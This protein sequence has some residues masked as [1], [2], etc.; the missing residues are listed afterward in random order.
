MYSG[1]RIIKA[2][3]FVFISII[4]TSTIFATDYIQL[5][6]DKSFNASKSK[7]DPLR[8]EVLG[9]QWFLP[10]TLKK[11]N[12][13][14]ITHDV[15]GFQEKVPFF[16]YGHKSFQLVNEDIN[17]NS[18]AY[19]DLP[20]PT[21]NVSNIF[22]LLNAV[23]LLPDGYLTNYTDTV[24]RILLFYQNPESGETFV[25]TENGLPGISPS[26][27]ELELKGGDMVRNNWTGDSIFG[28]WESN[29]LASYVT[30]FWNQ[31][32]NRGTDSTGEPYQGNDVIDILHVSLPEELY[33]YEL[34][35]IGISP[36]YRFVLSNDFRIYSGLMLYGI[37]VGLPCIN[38]DSPEVTD[39]RFKFKNGDNGVFIH[40]L[41]GTSFSP[42]FEFD[43]DWKEQNSF[44]VELYSSDRLEWVTLDNSN[45]TVFEGL[46]YKFNEKF[47]P[48]NNK[49]Q[50]Y[51]V[52]KGDTKTCPTTIEFDIMECPEELKEII[53]DFKED[54][55]N[56]GEF[57]WESIRNDFAIDK[58]WT[59]EPLGITFVFKLKP[60]VDEMHYSIPK[61]HFKRE[62]QAEFNFLPF[63]PVF[64]NWE[65]SFED[66]TTD[67]SINFD[68]DIGK[69]SLGYKIDLLKKMKKNIGKD[70][71]ENGGLSRTFKTNLIAVKEADFIGVS[72]FLNKL[73]N[74]TLPRFNIICEPI[75]YW[76]GY[77]PNGIVFDFDQ[78]RLELH[79]KIAFKLP[80]INTPYPG[81]MGYLNLE[82][83]G[84]PG[85]DTKE[86][87]VSRYLFNG[88]CAL[89]FYKWKL[90]DPDD[91]DINYNVSEGDVSWDSFKVIRNTKNLSNY[92]SVFG[93]ISSTILSDATCSFNTL[94]EDANPFNYFT[95]EKNTDQYNV[96]YHATNKNDNNLTDLLH[97]HYDGD[98]WYPPIKVSTANDYAQ[99]PQIF[100]SPKNNKII[101]WESHDYKDN[102][103]E[104]P[105]EAAKYAEIVFSQYDTTTNTWSPIKSLTNNSYNDTQPKVSIYPGKDNLL[106]TY[107]QNEQNIVP[108][109]TND[110][111]IMNRLIFAELNLDTE[112]LLNTSY[113][114]NNMGYIVYY[115]ITSNSESA[116]CVWI[117]DQDNDLTTIEDH[118]IYMTKYDTNKWIAPIKVTYNDV[119]DYS[120]NA[121]I[122]EDNLIIFW[123]N[124][125]DLCLYSTETGE[126]NIIVE[127][128]F[129]ECGDNYIIR[130]NSN[131]S[132]SIVFVENNINL[133]YMY[134][135]DFDTSTNELIKRMYFTEPNYLDI[136]ESIISDNKNEII[137]YSIKNSENLMS[138]ESIILYEQKQQDNT[139]II[140]YFLY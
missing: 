76:R 85:Y 87:L 118:E 114:A 57:K 86:G 12:T 129:N 137:F 123:L 23:K 69:A 29:Y 113:I 138:N 74:Q 41:S 34:V 42:Y 36:F 66:N 97:L 32:R 109:L 139:N 124:K 127:D 21:K 70:I 104:S 82:F 63:L 91:D 134:S 133:S 115:D 27:P 122:Q 119:R 39:F 25:I 15:N 18:I 45:T 16:V 80:F 49:V 55:E 5:E 10:D 136:K 121:Y 20:E 130:R 107:I 135:Y 100:T 106:I 9:D 116:Y 75:F 92:P 125:Y 108:L 68:N 64:S 117:E 19:F 62:R 53:G 35:S 99:Y 90:I 72:K 102:N 47:S 105:I 24:G 48:T 28:S 96:C 94:I 83:D 120:L 131:T 77:N 3:I 111:S 13:E 2:I 98:E 71:W 50:I 81:F 89:Y 8:S 84:Y 54:W 56:A 112:Q 58:E 17:I 73:F 38:P 43:M 31:P 78:F 51:P 46:F 30:P 52:V 95:I 44:G 101:I 6:L 65:S 60:L 33:D 79:L 22:L 11:G 37:T 61:S 88:K 14:S 132:F 40:G 128:F 126:T 7:L 93:L 110:I 4:I 26:I 59:F 67:N 140:D 1:K 103:I